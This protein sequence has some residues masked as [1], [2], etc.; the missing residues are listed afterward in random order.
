MPTNLYYA[1]DAA[2]DISKSAIHNISCNNSLSLYEDFFEN[3]I[4]GRGE[5]GNK[6]KFESLFD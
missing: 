4:Y 2:D 3:I 5:G 1:N 6:C